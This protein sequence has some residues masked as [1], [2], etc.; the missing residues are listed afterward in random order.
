M[1]V[2][3]VQTGTVISAVKSEGRVTSRATTREI[4]NICDTGRTVSRAIDTF[5]VA[6]VVVPSR[7][8]NYSLASVINVSPVGLGPRAVTSVIVIIVAETVTAVKA[9]TSANLA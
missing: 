3:T 8:F 2:L 1:K 9:D 6:K 7:A 4:I 5:I